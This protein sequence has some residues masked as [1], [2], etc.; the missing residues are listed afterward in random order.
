MT[1]NNENHDEIYAIVRDAMDKSISINDAVAKLKGLQDGTELT[2]ESF[3]MADNVVSKSESKEEKETRET[4]EEA[5][6]N[7][8]SF[9]GT[10]DPGKDADADINDIVGVDP[11]DDTTSLGV[12]SEDDLV[13]NK[14][15]D[16]NKVDSGEKATEDGEKERS[17]VEEPKKRTKRTKGE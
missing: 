17:D 2:Q 6:Q 1:T 9:G 8:L 16:E 11:A 13:E 4:Q 10:V 3:T 14:S 5:V 12:V 7:E 15:G